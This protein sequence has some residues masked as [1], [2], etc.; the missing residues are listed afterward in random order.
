M[1][2]LLTSISGHGLYL[3]ANGNRYK[4]DYVNGVKE[5]R[6]QFWWTTGRYANDKYVGQFHLDR[7][8]GHGV[9]FYS[10]GEI[11]DG[12]WA[13]GHQEGPGQI[14]FSNG[15]VMEGIWSEGRRHGDFKFLYPNG[16]EFSA[17]FIRGERTTQ[18]TQ[19]RS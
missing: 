9:Y 3:F 16:D 13:T 7:R 17:H 5:G 11:F 12:Q 2:I 19:S 8:H 14:L 4:G 1:K 18:W 10:N 6:G 15:N